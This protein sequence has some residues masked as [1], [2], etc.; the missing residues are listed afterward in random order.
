MLAE[1][2][3]PVNAVECGF[4]DQVVDRSELDDSARALAIALAGLDPAAH[5][6]TKERARQQTLSALREAMEADAADYDGLL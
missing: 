4:L 5:L 6:A 3:S 1:V 2:F